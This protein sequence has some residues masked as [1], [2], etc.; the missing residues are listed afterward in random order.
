MASK[1]LKLSNKGDLSVDLSQKDFG[2]SDAFADNNFWHN[3]VGGPYG[4][5][6]TGI[7]VNPI[8]SLSVGTVFSCISILTGDLAKLPLKLMRENDEN[9]WLED[10]KHPLA[11]L[12]RKPNR[13]MTQSDFITNIV[14]SVL[15]VGNAFIAVIRDN[16]GRP[17]E[18]IPLIP[19]TVSIREDGDGNLFYLCTNRLFP[20]RKVQTFTEDDMVHI[21]GGISL[22]G[23][24]R[25]ASI[26]QLASETLGLGIATQQLCGEMFRNG[27]HFQGLLKT[28]QRLTKEQIESTS[29]NWKQRAGG[30]VNAYRT[31]ILQGGLEFQP[32]QQD[33]TQL[34]MVETR[35]QLVEEVARLFKVPLYKLS[36]VD[37]MGYNSIDAQQQDYIDSTL[38]P[39][40]NPIEQSLA[41]TLLFDREF[42]SLRFA[43]DFDSLERGDIKTR[44]D[45]QHSMM[46]DG[47]FSVN[48]VRKQM[49]LPSIG[50]EGDIRTKPINT[51]V[52]GDTQGLPLYQVEAPIKETITDP[53]PESK[54]NVH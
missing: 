32:I 4:Q 2:T 15:L 8:S 52:V 53:T 50:P 51:G 1:L 17:I 11:R 9:I 34:Q 31:P 5:S 14:M 26:T 39:L 10:K 33:A 20:D 44:T 38:I 45:F 21:R 28:D 25:S 16:D 12:L 29:E 49:N 23:G 6:H 37:K 27:A 19:N 48:E 46:S 30:V 35:R 7:N 18:L 36:T 54:P 41:K 40:A 47:V 24:I 13:R 43:F 3:L 42:D 22:D